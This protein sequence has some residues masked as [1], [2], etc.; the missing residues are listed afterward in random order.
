MTTQTS[1]LL[2]LRDFFRNPGKTNFQISPDGT[3]ISFLQS[4]NNRLNI[5]VY[6]RGREDAIRQITTETRRDIRA[7]FWKNDKTLLYIQ[8]FGGDE[9]DHLYAVD[10]EESTVRD[11]TPYDNVKVHIIDELKDL[12]DEVLISIN[13]RDPR[14]FDVY[15]LHIQSGALELEYENPGNITD[16]FTDHE[17]RLRVVASTDGVSTTLFAREIDGEDFRPVLTTDFREMIY[18]LF[19]TFD[20]TNVYAA[21]N[22]GRDKL[23]VVE[24]DL[25]TGNEVRVLF[26]HDEVDVS[27]LHY[28]RKRKVLTSVSYVTW[29]QERTFLDDTMRTI[30]SRLEELLPGYEISLA[31]TTNEED[32]YIVRTYSDR[33]LGAF[34]LFIPAENSLQKL[35]D[36]SPWLDENKLAPVQPVTFTSRDGLTL[37]GYLTLPVG[38]PA[39]GLPV[40]LNPHGGP[41]MRD[42]W[43]FNPEVQFLANR[44]YA[45]LQVNYRS[46]TG[47]GKAFWEAGFKQWG[48]RM[49]DDLTD[50]VQWLIDRGIAD[51]ARIAI[52]GGSYGGYAT[53]AG[54][55][56]T[57]DLYACGV[58]YVG[59]SNIFTFIESIPPYWKPYL[60]M[61]YEMVGH[62][63][64]DRELLHAVSPLFHVHNIKAPL[65]VAQGANDPRVKIQE[66][67]QIVQALR[68]RGI[69]TPYIVKHDE[70]H[71]FHNEENRFEFYEAMESFLATHLSKTNRTDD[72]YGTDNVA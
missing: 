1:S 28:S 47:Y 29:K 51:P 67:D 71:G 36:V 56:F 38:V 66:S 31:C 4:Y 19:F 57:P 6:E 43:S 42:V 40:V 9:N 5:F 53:L 64:H 34:Y 69:A 22:I 68:D 62:P 70:G 52:Y 20:N 27:M 32:M 21:S 7:Y 11:L 55:A 46:S 60:E 17:G 44:G 41:W 12:P 39:T 63:V 18:P 13:T 14:I 16:F 54:L 2:P 15:R 50:G 23:A 45:V 33:S 10:L 8:D 48:R 61:M 25:A 49:Q 3:F 35:A 37:H 30:Y 65:L 58:D 72:Q 59:V 24:Y 26:E